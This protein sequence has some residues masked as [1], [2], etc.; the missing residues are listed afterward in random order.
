MNKKLDAFYTRQHTNQGQESPNP[1]CFEGPT[2]VSLH[3]DPC[4]KKNPHIAMFSLLLPCFGLA[5]WSLTFVC[6]TYCPSTDHHKT[7]LTLVQPLVFTHLT[8]PKGVIVD[9]DDV[10]VDPHRICQLLSEVKFNQILQHRF[11]IRGILPLQREH[12]ELI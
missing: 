6:F 3:D 1:E 11:T 2:F 12:V 8:F 4:F 10:F 9:D 7:Y 5:S